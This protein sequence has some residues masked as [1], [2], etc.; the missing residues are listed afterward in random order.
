MVSAL[1]LTKMTKMSVA[2]QTLTNAYTHP[3]QRDEPHCSAWFL[4]CIC[5]WWCSGRWRGH[6]LSERQICRGPHMMSGKTCY[7]KTEKRWYKHVHM[8]STDPQKNKKHWI[9][10]D[11]LKYIQYQLHMQIFNHR[12]SIQSVTDRITIFGL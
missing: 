3:A 1:W 7:L 8:N 10:Y 12:K 6:P 9:L 4:R 2:Q 5:A 11:S